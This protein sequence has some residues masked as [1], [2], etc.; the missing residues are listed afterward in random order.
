MS[1]K[2]SIGFGFRG[3]MLIVYQFIAFLTFTVFT[4]WPMNALSDLY[5]GQIVSTIYTVAQVVGIG[6]QL[7]LS[8]NI[9][10]VKN[11][12][13]L[14]IIL[15]AV[16]LVFALGIM[17]IPPAMATLWYV[18]YFL[19]SFIVTIWCT[20]T[21][22]ILIGQWFPRRKGTVMGIVTFSFPI[23][24]ALVSPFAQAVF[25]NMATTHIPNIAGAFLPY[26]I[27]GIVGLL[28]GAIFVKDY[29]EQCGCFRDNDKSFTPEIA[30][31]M[32]EAEIENKKTTVWTLGNT[33]KSGAFWCLSLPMGMLLMA[34]IGMMTQTIPILGA[35]GIASDSAQ[36][37]MIMLGIC[38]VACL[39]SWVLG[40]IDTRFGTKRAL[41][42]SAFLMLLSGAFGLAGNFPCLLAAL[43]CLAAFM[44]S[45]SNF[46]VSGAVQYW[47]IE[48]FPSV[49]ARINPV[50]SLLSSFGPMLVAI[51]LFSKGYPT[52]TAPF[53]FV[54]ICGVLSIILVLLFKPAKV[55]ETDDKYRAAAGKPLD[56]VLV[57][58][59]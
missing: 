25:K 45:A 1:N 24:N 14:S 21:I 52:P 47:R 59:K 32:M 38:V 11:I 40:L 41:T 23:G 6:T 9:G 35:Y 43:A 49:F 57:G 33:L 16:S 46:T 3:W 48:D 28:I 2:K 56:D 26:F 27:L 50:A 4:N 54:G 12:K 58:R 13:V 7:V 42:I 55:K 20:F 5:G 30:K 17:V 31:A 18:A 8:R 51:L 10:K 53:T 34:S 19:E 37:G 29:P 44:G 22:G 15:G 39:G 36:F